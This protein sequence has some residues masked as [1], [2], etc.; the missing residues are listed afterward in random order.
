MEKM[1]ALGCGHCLV[2][3]WQ[4]PHYQLKEEANR[5]KK[6]RDKR[7]MKEQSLGPD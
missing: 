7:I 4:P 1:A 2:R 5:E 3:L 6:G